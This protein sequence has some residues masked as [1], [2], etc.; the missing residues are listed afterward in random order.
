MDI[1][2]KLYN[3]QIYIAE[4][5]APKTEE[6]KKASHRLSETSQK[7]ENSLDENQMKLF[8]AVQAA[9][10]DLDTLVQINV[11]RQG[12][13]FGFQLKSELTE[14]KTDTDDRLLDTETDE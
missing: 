4:S 11:F 7:L 10:A 12:V 2:K 1:F 3:G 5:S 6:Y 9:R 8:E 14:E 13:K